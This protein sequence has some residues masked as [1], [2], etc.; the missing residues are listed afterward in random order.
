M[1]TG[2]GKAYPVDGRVCKSGNASGIG[3]GVQSSFS[4]SSSAGDN[5]G[6]QR[7]NA[8]FKTLVMMLSQSDSKEV[9][10]VTY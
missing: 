7:G 6:S 5:G 8:L 2:L 9:V 10:V 4:E 3:N 1:R